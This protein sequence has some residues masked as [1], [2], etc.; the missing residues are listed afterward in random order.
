MSPTVSITVIIILPSSEL[1]KI[2]DHIV[3]RELTKFTRL[4]DKILGGRPR[5][6]V[7]ENRRNSFSLP[8][9]DL[10]TTAT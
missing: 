7:E 1:T 10:S 6:G 5:I 4:S 9:T 3:F 2:P 8:W